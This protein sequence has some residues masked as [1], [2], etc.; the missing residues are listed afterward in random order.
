[1]QETPLACDSLHVVYPTAL[2]YTHLVIFDSLRNPLLSRGIADSLATHHL[3]GSECRLFPA[4]NPQSLRKGVCLAE[5]QG[6]RWL[7]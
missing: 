6:P 2:S 3:K 4:D 5:S 1:M 7:R